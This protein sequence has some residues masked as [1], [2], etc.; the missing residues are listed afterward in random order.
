MR[1]WLCFVLLSVASAA[2]AAENVD[3]SPMPLKVVRAF[4]DLSLERPIVLTWDGVHRD[5]L[6]VVNQLGKICRMKND[7]KA[8]S[9]D[10]EL[11]LDMEEKVFYKDTENEQGLLGLAFHPKFKENG[12]F[13]I[14]Y[15]TVE[16]PPHTNV[17]A[18]V[19]MGKDGKADAKSIEELLRIEHPFWNH[20]GGGLAFGPDGYLYI[21]VGDGGK[22]DDP[23]NNAQNIDSLLG[24]ILRIDID[25]KDSGKKY[26]IPKDNPFANQKDAR[27]EVFAY[28]LRNVWGMSFDPETKLF[29][30]ADVGQDIWEEIDLIV[31]GG[32]YG[33]NQREG[34]HRFT[35]GPGG[36]SE[37]NKK[38]IEPIWDYHHDVGK[39]IT[40]GLVYRGKKLP[41]LVG[42]YL[43]ADYVTGKVWALKYDQK[44]GKTVEN[45]EIATAKPMPYI[46]I[47]TDANGEVYL[48]DSLGQVWTVEKQ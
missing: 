5:Q 10:L 9:D 31:S 24:K 19:R 29:W 4:P 26:A 45:R 8:T 44:A 37:P 43:Y 38:Y 2:V 47:G 17:I 41:D 34:F 27:G 6:Y 32:N 40:G 35:M 1:R 12:E 30:A 21:S 23:F 3:T 48:T 11:V 39:S 7:P 16:E 18:R 46:A 33:W 42:Y 28:G 36:G 15:T 20:K 13:F 25:H 14:H 22:R